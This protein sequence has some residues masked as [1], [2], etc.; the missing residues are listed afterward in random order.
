MFLKKNDVEITYSSVSSDE[1]CYGIRIE[2]DPNGGLSFYD[3]PTNS[4]LSWNKSYD[5]I[6]GELYACWLDRVKVKKYSKEAYEFERNIGKELDRLTKSILSLQWRPRGYYD[7]MVY[8]PTRIISAPYYEDRIVEEWLA[9]NYL[10]LYAENI[11]HPNNVACQTGKGPALAQKYLKE[12]LEEL[13]KIYGD[14]F[15]FLQYDVKGY[16][17]NMSHER[18]KEQFAGMPALG[19]E[20]FCNIIDDWTQEEGYASKVDPEGRYGVPKGNLPSQ[21]AGIMY[22]ND[23]DWYIAER[24]DCL[25]TIRYMDDAMSFFEKKES[26]KDCKI[27]IEKYLK[28]NE[29][30]IVLHPKKTVYAPISRG[31]SFCGWH[32][33]ISNDGKVILSVK[34]DRKKLI[35]Q[36]YEKMRESYYLGKLSFA[37]VLA[38]QNGTYAFLEQ[39]DTR[40]F[41]RYLS[42]RYR[43]THDPDTFYKRKF[44]EN[45]NKS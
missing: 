34:H 25:G 9:D 12:K 16:F 18:I 23:V 7:F 10:K 32:Y 19:Y 39:G 22:L 5:E 15:Y 42:D 40:K 20:L 33:S 27:H 44:R 28:E 29:M 3:D 11:I 1:M 13:Y 38:K 37:D 26:C 35:K 43:F 45:K 4:Y 6:F 8:H 2:R 21:W 17:D 14:N 30:G 31:F 36:K 24:E 41:R